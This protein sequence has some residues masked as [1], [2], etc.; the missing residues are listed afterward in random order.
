MTDGTIYCKYATENFT[1]SMDRIFCFDYNGELFREVDRLFS[2]E[3]NAKHDPHADLKNEIVSSLKRDYGTPHT[4][5]T[6]PESKYYWVYGNMRIDYLDS[7]GHIAI[8]YSHI[9]K[10]REILAENDKNKSYQDSMAAE[11]NNQNKLQQQREY[12]RKRNMT[13]QDHVADDAVKEYEIAERQGDKM[14]MY[15]QAGLCAAAFLQA[16]DEPNY[17]KWKD[18]ERKIGDQ[19]RMPHY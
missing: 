17:R 13:I 10:E 3:S 19:I 14:Q 2:F 16:Q 18:I 1:Y 9:P 8:A 6:Q 7:F 15:V 12:E 5:G 11:I 4:N